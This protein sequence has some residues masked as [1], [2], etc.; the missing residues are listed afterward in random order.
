MIVIAKNIQ[1]IHNSMESSM[2]ENPLEPK[3]IHEEADDVAGNLNDNNTDLYN[4]QLLDTVAELF[5]ATGCLL[6]ETNIINQSFA[7]KVFKSQD[8]VKEN[9]KTKEQRNCFISCDVS[10]PEILT[11]PYDSNSFS[12]V[13][14]TAVSEL[15]T[16][17]VTQFI[18]IAE[19]TIES[20][21]NEAEV[22]TINATGSCQSIIE[23][24]KN[25]KLDDQHSVHLK[26]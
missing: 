15:N 12:N 4:E 7:V 26:F 3:T 1:T 20:N 14:Q 10:E 21:I 9:Q 25:A 2:T 6:E 11:E 24:G 5:A 17:A 16:L 8:F 19:D 23:W 22:K 13:F 18:L